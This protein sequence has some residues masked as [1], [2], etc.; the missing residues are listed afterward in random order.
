M[1]KKYLL[2]AFGAI[3]VYSAGVFA[4]QQT[5]VLVT[6]MDHGYSSDS[7]T[8]FIKTVEPLGA[9][10]PDQKIY[11][12]TSTYAGKSA[13]C[14]LQFFLNRGTQIRINYNDSAQAQSTVQ[15]LDPIQ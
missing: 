11:W 10:I 1:V 7:S 12:S 9:N 4:T 6:V 15:I 2:I 14:A 3:L 5:A 8:Y 13:V